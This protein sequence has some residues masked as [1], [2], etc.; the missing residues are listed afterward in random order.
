MKTTPKCNDNEHNLPVAWSKS[1][2]FHFH[3]LSSIIF[4]VILQTSERDKPIKIGYIIIDL[5]EQIFLYSRHLLK[6]RSNLAAPL[7][8]PANHLYLRTVW[9]WAS[10]KL[11]ESANT[12][13]KAF[14]KYWLSNSET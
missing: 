12:C 5:L 9:C 11:S 3:S 6:A 10:V 8:S 7:C 14:A 1:K 2:F 13:V 4:G